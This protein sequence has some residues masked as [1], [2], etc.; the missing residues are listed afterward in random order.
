MIFKIIII[1]PS[2]SWYVKEFPTDDVRRCSIVFAVTRHYKSL[3][4]QISMGFQ[5]F[6][7][8]EL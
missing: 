3:P 7:R 4:E 5:L 8:W 2:T 6:N 1:V